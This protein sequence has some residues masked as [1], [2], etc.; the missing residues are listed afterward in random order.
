MTK[1]AS[2]CPTEPRLPH[3]I[4][5]DRA[6]S[7]IARTATTFHNE[8]CPPEPRLAQT[9]SRTTRRATR[10]H[11]CTTNVPPSLQVDASGYSDCSTD[12]TDTNEF[13]DIVNINYNVNI[14]SEIFFVIIYDKSFKVK[15]LR[16]METLAMAAS[17]GTI[18]SMAKK[19]TTDTAEEK[20][21]GTVVVYGR[22]PS[23]MN[24]ILQKYVDGFRPKTSVSAL[25]QMLLEDHLREKN[26][27]PSPEQSEESSP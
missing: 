1:P 24:E 20:K 15:H 27:W 14:L 7:W 4:K 23:D 16:Q 9:A 18:S 2:P 19:K 26:L 12:R 25:I 11:R 13:D 8:T 22:I 5:P 6:E 21:P 10:Y 17:F 3:R